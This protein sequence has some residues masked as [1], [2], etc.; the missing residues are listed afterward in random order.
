MT[1]RAPTA[2]NAGRR[3]MLPHGAARTTMTPPDR[4]LIS[5]GWTP[6]RLTALIAR[7]I[8]DLATAR[9]LTEAQMRTHYALPDRPWMGTD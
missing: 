9:G 1:T 5:R 2:A 4:A 3:H 6:T 8:A 7:L